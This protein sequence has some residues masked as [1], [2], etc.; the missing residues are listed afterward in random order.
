MTMVKKYGDPLVVNLHLHEQ[1]DELRET[2]KRCDRLF[3]EALPKF[4]WARSALDANA[5]A[6]LNEVPGEV[7]AALARVK[8]ASR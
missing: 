8:G 2:L 6:L 5:I 1:V 7:R 3:T 4:D